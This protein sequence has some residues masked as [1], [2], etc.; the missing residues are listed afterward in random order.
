M[1]YA[2]V[3]LCGWPCVYTCDLVESTCHRYTWNISTY[4]PIYIYDIYIY[5]F[6]YI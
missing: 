3:L 4:L 2:Y 5:I 6:I 1:L